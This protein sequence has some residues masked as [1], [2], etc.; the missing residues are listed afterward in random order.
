MSRD[1][2]S[3]MASISG[4]SAENRIKELMEILDKIMEI[5]IS[6]IDSITVNIQQLEIRVQTLTR[7]IVQL[8]TAPR[9][10]LGPT[11]VASPQLAGVPQP[12]PAPAA[13]PPPAPSSAPPVSSRAALQGELKA[14]FAKR[15]RD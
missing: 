9:A 4:E 10:A 5:S 11:G 14:L 6:S 2:A 8:E 1:F 3:F 7:R 13:P 12:V 15:K